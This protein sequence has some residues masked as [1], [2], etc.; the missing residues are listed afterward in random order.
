MQ[1]DD[2]GQQTH[3][4]TRKVAPQSE[5]QET[6]NQDEI[7]EVSE[8]ANLGG[9]PANHQQFEKQCKQTPQTQLPPRKASENVRRNFPFLRPARWRPRGLAAGRMEQADQIYIG[10]D[11]SQHDEGKRCEQTPIGG[12]RS[13]ASCPRAKPQRDRRTPRVSKGFCIR[14]NPASVILRIS[15]SVEKVRK[16]GAVSSANCQRKRVIRT[17]CTRGYWIRNPRP[18]SHCLLALARELEANG[19]GISAASDWVGFFASY[20]SITNWS[21]TSV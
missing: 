19:V 16:G 10:Q 20:R 13:R 14:R 18:P 2:Q 21:P 8:D 15:E 17:T 7:L 6:S 5:T 3:T 4:A 9:D 1:G 11:S 12:S